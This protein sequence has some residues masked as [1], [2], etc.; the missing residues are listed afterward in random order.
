MAK[1]RHRALVF[2]ENP[3]VPIELTDEEL[4]LVREG[5]AAAARGELIDA[6]AFLAS[7][8]RASPKQQR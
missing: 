7:L 6:R 3:D 1:A 4:A 2:D 8:V 5:Q